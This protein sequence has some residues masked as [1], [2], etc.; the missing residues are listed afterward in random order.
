ME[1]IGESHFITYFLMEGSGKLYTNYAPNNAGR[2]LYTCQAT[3]IDEG[4]ATVAI[5]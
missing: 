3:R 1:E 4:D 2:L 5:Y